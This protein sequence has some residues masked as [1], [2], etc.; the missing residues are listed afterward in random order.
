MH[1]LKKLQDRYKKGELTKAQYLAEIKAL[2]TDEYI[3]QEEHDEAVSFDPEEGKPI[4]TQADVD[5]FIAKKAI[6]MVRKA[7]KDAGVEV[8][9]NNKELLP[10]LVELAKTGQAGEG[11]A[12]DKDLERLKALEAKVPGLETK[13]K[14][15][16]IT[17][18]VMATAAK[19][20]PYNPAQVVRA[21]K[22]DY[23]DLVEVDEETGEIDTKTVE[24]ALKRIKDAEPNLFKE[25]DGGEDG[26]EGDE[27]NQSGG[28]RSKTPGGAGGG[29]SAKDKAY[30]A[31]K[32]KALEMLGITPDKK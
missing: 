25:V 23:M 16:T 22:L 15:L 24:K 8:E 11:K 18:A 7:L 27:S 12:T 32:A 5:S 6:S 10:K 4:Y 30:A 26:E 31:N 3:D 28:F 2:L 17:N 13:V 29:M 1:K 9:G 21:L 19:Y 14:D 20:N